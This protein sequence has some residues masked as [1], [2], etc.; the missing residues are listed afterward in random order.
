LRIDYSL[1]WCRE[2]AF[3]REMT[4]NSATDPALVDRIKRLAPAAR[5]E[6]G[7]IAGIAPDSSV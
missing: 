7:N 4:D 5:R 3:V 1:Q 2:A 6:L